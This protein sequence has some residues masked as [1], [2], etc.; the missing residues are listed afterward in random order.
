[1]ELDI[2]FTPSMLQHPRLSG[3]EIDVLYLDNTYM[4]PK[5]TFPSR[6]D[7]AMKCLA[8]LEAHPYNTVIIGVD[9]LGKEDLLYFLAKSLKQPVLT[10]RA[11]WFQALPLTHTIAARLQF[12]R[13]AWRA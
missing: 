8:V 1:M 4:D 11:G 5:F 3:V 12:H 2:R 7:A 9:S 13:S 10:R 6:E